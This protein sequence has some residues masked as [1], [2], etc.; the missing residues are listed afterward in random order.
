VNPEEQNQAAAGDRKQN[1]LLSRLWANSRTYRIILVC[2]AL[3]GAVI[4][5]PIQHYV[6][7]GRFQH[8]GIAAFIAG[9]GFILEAIWSWRL[10]LPWGRA[11]VTGTGVFLASIGLVYYANPGLDYRMAVETE[12]TDAMKDHLLAF[13]VSFSLILILIWTRWVVEEFKAKEA[14]AVRESEFEKHKE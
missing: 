10:F 11:S 1:S 7:L 13:Y 6:T 8:Y 9:M 4:S 14:A 12:A 2:A 5:T 3:A